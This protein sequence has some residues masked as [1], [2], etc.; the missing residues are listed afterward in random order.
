MFCILFVKNCTSWHS[1]ENGSTCKPGSCGENDQMCEC[2]LTI[3]H[4]LTMMT[5]NPPILVRPYNGRLYLYNDT[6]HRFPL[7][8]E[9]VSD[10]ITGDGYGSR[11]VIAVNGKFPGPTIE[12]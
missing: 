8:D 6:D 5:T 12:A 10:V 11:L 3:E 4:R 1:P 7:T 9:K 2:F